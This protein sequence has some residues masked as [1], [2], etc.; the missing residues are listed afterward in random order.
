[1]RRLRRRLAHLPWRTA[2][3]LALAT[4][5]LVLLAFV[6]WRSWY[7]VFPARFTGE[8]WLDCAIIHGGLAYIAWRWL[9]LARAWWRW[10]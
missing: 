9:G 7:A 10:G 1:V 3:T 5:G 4:Y 8:Q 6:W 2:I